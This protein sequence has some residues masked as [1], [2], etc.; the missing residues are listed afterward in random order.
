[1]NK[2]KIAVVGV[3]GI[4]ATYGGIEKHC[5][6][7]YPIML[8]H[9][10]EITLYA[11]DYYYDKNISEYNG[12]KIKT[13]PIINI[14]GFETFVHSFIATILATFSDADIIHFHAQGPAI[15]SWIP[16]I[17]APKKMICFTCNGL[18]KDRDKWNKIA[19]FIITLGE[20]AS[21][22]FPHCRIGV[23]E[24]IKNYYETK[25]NIEMHK[26][27][28]GISTRET[29][30][31][32]NCKRFDIETGEYFMFVGRLVPEKAPETLIKAFK[33]VKTNKK[34]LI[35]GDSAGTDDY[36]KELKEL[37]A[38]DDRIIF[39]S[40]VYGDDLTEL[41]SNAFFYASSSKLEGLPL[42]ILEALSFSLPVILSD[43]PPH[44]E[45]LNQGYDVG[46][47]FEVNN[48]DSCLQAIENIL[49]L[50]QDK[51]IEMKT[52]S[53]KLVNDVFDWEKVGL[54]T[55]NLFNET[56]A[57]LNIFFG[58]NVDQSETECSNLKS[59]SEE[60]KIE[61]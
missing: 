37:A 6:M 55:I 47:S 38:D 28:N 14:K 8:K 9:D 5:E 30:P 53:K 20:I 12:V 54:Q 60:A 39:T 16:R 19:K 3:R 26:V 36:V 46:F 15:F 49:S 44:L 23:S 48:V 27:F 11:R 59:D 25:Y 18:D 45:V 43:I 40:Y 58:A 29:L 1:M 7:L 32:N 31:L 4:P 61:N 33:K 51:I 24:D 52:N 13:I 56:L 42:T 50:P 2:K 34:L 21:A 22:K 41:Y 10:F 17:F 35:V 57:K